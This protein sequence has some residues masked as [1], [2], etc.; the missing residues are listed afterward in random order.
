[1]ATAAAGDKCCG[2]SLI[3]SEEVEAANVF[4]ATGCVPRDEALL[5]LG[6]LR[7]ATPSAALFGCT[8]PFIQFERRDFTDAPLEA[9]TCLTRCC[10]LCRLVVVKSEA[11]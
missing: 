2:E 4:V 5:C 10:G 11:G 8:I 9:K 3:R 7:F 1:M 6:K